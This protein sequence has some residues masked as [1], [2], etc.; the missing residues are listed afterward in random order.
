MY[1]IQ[2]KKI[3]ERLRKYYVGDASMKKVY[4]GG[5]DGFVGKNIENIVYMLL[6]SYGRK[7]F[8]GKI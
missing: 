5:Y 1:D 4:F 3:F 2:G 6:V 8:V 7:V